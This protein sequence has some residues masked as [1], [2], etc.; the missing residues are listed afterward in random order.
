LPL[1]DY[2]ALTLLAIAHAIVFHYIDA[3]VLRLHI[4]DTLSHYAMP[5]LIFIAIDMP[6]RHLAI[7]PH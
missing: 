5:L 6:L 4:I 2:I 3:A 7:S 1:A